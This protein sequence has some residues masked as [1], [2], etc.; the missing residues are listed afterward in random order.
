MSGALEPRVADLEARFAFLDDQVQQLDALL[1]AQR[2]ALDALRG[3]VERI[4]E[5]LQSMRLDMP[6]GS[7]EPPPP[8]Y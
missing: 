6:D 4:R 8:H 3:E 1:T 2:D 5:T 7:A